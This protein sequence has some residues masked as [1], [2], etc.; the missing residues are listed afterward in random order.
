MRVGILVYF[1]CNYIP[2]PILLPGTYLLK[3][4]VL[5]KRI[6]YLQKKKKCNVGLTIIEGILGF[7][8]TF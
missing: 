8:N 7:N 4:D 1:I 2:E 5:I 3:N 6:E